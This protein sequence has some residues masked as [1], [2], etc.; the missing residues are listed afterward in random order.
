VKFP[1]K[2]FTDYHLTH[3][4]PKLKQVARLLSLLPLMLTNPFLHNQ[5]MAL[6]SSNDENASNGIQN[7][8]THED[9]CICVNM[10]KYQINVATR[11]HDYSSSQTVPGVQSPPPP[12]VPL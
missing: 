4:Y 9:N 5:H 6:S 7:P 2:I 10:V 1:F 8:S 3:L 12:K 11:S